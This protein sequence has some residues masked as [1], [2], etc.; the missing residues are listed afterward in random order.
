MICIIQEAHDIGVTKHVRLHQII[1][2]FCFK[3][4][5]DR[6]VTDFR[7]WCYRVLPEFTVFFR[8][9]DRVFP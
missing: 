1:W 3:V 9:E 6:Q 5:T 2:S 4:H 8:E 7:E